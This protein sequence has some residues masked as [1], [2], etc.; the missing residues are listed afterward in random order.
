MSNVKCRKCQKDLRWPHNWSPGNRPVEIDGSRHLC[1]GEKPKVA[2]HLC[3]RNMA[4]GTERE[5]EVHLKL[6][7]PT[8]QSLSYDEFKLK[9]HNKYTGKRG[10]KS[11]EE[12]DEFDGQTSMLT[13]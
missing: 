5:I 7:H 3:P 9:F 8:E 4:M 1:Y 10:K 11:L 13:Y 6:Y 2:C 12:E